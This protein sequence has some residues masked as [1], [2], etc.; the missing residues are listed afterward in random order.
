[1]AR[2]VDEASGGS[3]LSSQSPKPI[4]SILFGKT[5][6]I[7]S[8]QL[9]HVNCTY[10]LAIHDYKAHSTCC[11]YLYTVHYNVVYLS[12]YMFHSFA[13]YMYTYYMGSYAT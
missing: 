1:M 2:P 9:P 10:A 6:Q 11:F 5:N 13:S 3:Q 4:E 7:H 8:V 12:L